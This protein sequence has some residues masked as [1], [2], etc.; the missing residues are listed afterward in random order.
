MKFGIGPTDVREF[1]FNVS[2]TKGGYASMEAKAIF[3]TCRQ[4]EVAHYIA[5]H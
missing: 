5:L 1:K 4:V 3:A 2:P